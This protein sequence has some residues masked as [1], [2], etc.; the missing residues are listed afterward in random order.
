MA[1]WPSPGDLF[2]I[3]ARSREALEDAV[4]YCLQKQ[5]HVQK[6]AGSSPKTSWGNV[7][8]MRHERGLTHPSAD[9][10]ER[11]FSRDPVYVELL[12]QVTVLGMNVVFLCLVK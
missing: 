5:A 1:L 4:T 10:T 7:V 6:V 9:D 2:G 8:S 3:A 12:P 11:H